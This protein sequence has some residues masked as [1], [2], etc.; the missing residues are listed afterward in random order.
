MKRKDFIPLIMWFVLITGIVVLSFIRLR[1]A[2]VVWDE[3]PINFDA[4]FIS[5]YIAWMLIELR[6]T[7]KDVN[8]KG[9][10]TSD[11]MTC[12]LYGLGQAFTFFTALWLP[13]IWQLPNIAHFV[14]ISLFIVGVC[15]RLW[16]ILTLGEFYSHRV[17]TLSQHQI[18]AS[19]PY[20]FT[21]HPAY[22]GMI[23]ANAGLTLF[24]FNWG[25]ICVFICILIPAILLRISIEEK[26]LFSIEGYSEFAKKRKRLFPAVW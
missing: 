21:R 15:Y 16:A 10:Q 6:V 13:S 4:I 23:V 12:Q 20:H 14:G 11:F 1:R 25:T 26:I 18:V 7:K 24:F 9:K 3:W 5:L 17:R 22:A 19:G 8:T 2:F